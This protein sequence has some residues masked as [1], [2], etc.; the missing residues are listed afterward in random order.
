M[1]AAFESQ[2][3]LAFKEEATQAF[4]TLIQ[5]VSNFAVKLYENRDTIAQYAS[6]VLT[7]LR[8]IGTGIKNVALFVIEHWSTI[9][10]IILGVVTAFA[11]FKVITGVIGLVQGAIG[12]F[13]AL[14]GA[15][16]VA[17]TAMAGLRVGMLAFPGGWIVAAIA[18]VVT[19]GILLYKNWDTVK[20]KAGQLKSW[21]QDKW[22]SIKDWTKSTWNSV[23]ESISNAMENAKTAVSNF[24]NPLLNFIDKAKG[25]WDKFKKAL[26]NFKLPKISMPKINMPSWVPG[27]KTGLERVP[28]DNMPARLHK[29]EAVLTASQA[30][31][32][33]KMG[34]LKSNGTKPVLDTTPFHNNNGARSAGSQAPTAPRSEGNTYQFGDIVIN[35]AQKTSKE[36]AR[37]IVLNI[38]HVINTGVT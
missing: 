26:S 15:L 35:G 10:P 36:M 38:Q 14:K 30:E 29:D 8:D 34:V 28:T 32:L 13:G 1:T 19:A 24:F 33:R 2:E 11:G 5:N 9:K 31:T 20:E 16:G 6:Q 21:V 3:F 18:A 37:E 4:A 7:I 12:A 23:K 22:Q 25:A 17:R 27:F